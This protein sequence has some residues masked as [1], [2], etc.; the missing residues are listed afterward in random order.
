[1][2]LQSD[3]DM[4]EYEAWPSVVTDQHFTSFE[5]SRNKCWCFLALPRMKSDM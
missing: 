4:L 3:I 5:F 2:V 1:M